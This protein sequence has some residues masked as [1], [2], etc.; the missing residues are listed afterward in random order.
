[1][2]RIEFFSGI[3]STPPKPMVD[4][5]RGLPVFCHEPTLGSKRTKI[6]YD[7]SRELP[8]FGNVSVADC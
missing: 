3:F 1:M 4:Y 8:A 5:S 2:R 7:D 6:A